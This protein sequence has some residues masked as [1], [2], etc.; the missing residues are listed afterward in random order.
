MHSPGKYLVPS[1][2]LRTKQRNKR[3]Q[4]CYSSEP[5]EAATGGPPST[6]RHW[7]SPKVP[8]LGEGGGWARVICAPHRE[9]QTQSPGERLLRIGKGESLRHASSVRCPALPVCC[10]AKALAASPDHR[11]WSTLSAF[12]RLKIFSSWPC[13]SLL[14]PSGN[15]PFSHS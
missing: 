7:S 9:F 11:H 1:C 8:V 2:L 6:R 3:I 12:S 14:P 13:P 10:P 4:V 5:P 15:F